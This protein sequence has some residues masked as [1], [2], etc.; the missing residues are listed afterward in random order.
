MKVGF[1]FG[2]RKTGANDV[3]ARSPDLFDLNN[4]D[5][6]HLKTIS[7]EVTIFYTNFLQFF[8]NYLDYKK[9]PFKVKSHPGPSTFHKTRKTRGLEYFVSAIETRV[10]PHSVAI[11]GVDDG[12]QA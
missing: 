10:S 3:H 8:R 6:R 12:R 9:Y 5:D 2:G 7:E 11:T 1:C 4:Y